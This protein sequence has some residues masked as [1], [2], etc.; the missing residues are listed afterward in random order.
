[1]MLFLSIT[2]MG[3]NIVPVGHQDPAAKAE[4]L[5]AFRAGDARF[6]CGQG[7]QCAV[8]WS[9]ARPAAQR[10]LL[11][12]R[13]DDVADVVLAAGYEQ[14]LTWFYLGIA[15]EGLG[16]G[17]VAQAYYDNAVRRTLYGAGY[18]CTAAGMMSC[19]GVRL[20]EDAQRLQAALARAPARRGANPA[21]RAAPLGGENARAYVQ[22]LVQMRAEDDA[23]RG[24]G[25]SAPSTATSCPANFRC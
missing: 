7:L 13:W 8:R 1:M 17:K 19:D 9:A 16:H 23:R 14:D 24:R 5:A 18:S 12:E 20:P 25:E 11:A 3:C 21:A 10:L 2:L 4:A 6:T 15:A 22:R